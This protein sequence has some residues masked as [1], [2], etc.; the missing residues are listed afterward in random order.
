M[1]RKAKIYIILLVWTAAIVQF[2]VNKGINREDKM[3]EAIVLADVTDYESE[4]SAYAYYGN[5]F[6]SDG[7][8][9]QMLIRLAGK[10]GISDGY[11]ITAEDSLDGSVM[12]FKK[13]GAEGDTTIRLVTMKQGDRGNRVYENYLSIEVRLHEK[14]ELSGSVRR[15]IEEL[16]LN[17][18]MEP[19]MNL[20]V[21]GVTMGG[22]SEAEMQQQID[23]FF[24]LMN[25][26]LVC[27][28]SFDNVY[29]VYGYTS[30]LPDYVYQNDEKVNVNIAFVY[31]E[32]E[33]RTQIH[34]AV[35]FVD[36]SY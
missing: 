20:Y 14:V 19:V 21:G 30:D 10:L 15:E 17:L 3:I 1:N 5:G 26:E 27:Q 32:S 22:M 28:E 7:T 11:E 25:A 24:S 8:K 31:D 29:T 35:P 6:I 9:R 12:T 16:Y 18:G 33:D 4:V 34:M 23:D 13:Q 2:F 36:R